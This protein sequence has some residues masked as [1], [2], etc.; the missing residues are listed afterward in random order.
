M[1]SQHP[2]SKGFNVWALLLCASFTTKPTTI[3]SSLSVLL[4]PPYPQ[5]AHVLQC[6]HLSGKFPAVT[7]P[8]LPPILMLFFPPAFAVTKSRLP[9]P[10]FPTLLSIRQVLTLCS[11]GGPHL[12][13]G[14]A[15]MS[16]WP[17]TLPFSPPPPPPKSGK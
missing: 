17:R 12:L 11:H 2:L 7:T 16:A 8:S 9:I 15:G 6:T 1:S 4:V 3:R 13:R 5:H 14:W 10:H